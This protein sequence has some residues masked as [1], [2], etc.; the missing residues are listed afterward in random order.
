MESVLNNPA[1]GDII[2][3]AV[4]VFGIALVCLVVV[5]FIKK[6]NKDKDKK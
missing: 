4:V 5:M 2:M 1:T 3:G 6:H